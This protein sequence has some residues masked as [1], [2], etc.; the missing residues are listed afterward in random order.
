[1]VQPFLIAR[2]LKLLNY[3]DKVNPKN[4]PSD[5]SVLHKDHEGPPR[6][7]EWQYQREVGMLTYLEGVT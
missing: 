2:F 6:K 4:K 3:D 1:M 7:F 5:K